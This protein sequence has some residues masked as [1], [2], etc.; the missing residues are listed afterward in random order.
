VA[1]TFTQNFNLQKPEVGASTDTWGTKINANLDIIDDVLS[2][3]RAAFPNVLV[4]TTAN[5]TLSGEQTIDGVLTSASRILVKDQAAP[6]NNGIY[7]TAAGSWVRAGDANSVEEFVLGRSVYVQSGTVGGGR[8]YRVVSSVIS[9]GT[10]PVAFSDAIKQGAA[11]L[12]ATTLAS[13]SVT[14]NETVGGTLSVTGN[15]TLGS[16]AGNSHVVNGNLSVEAGSISTSAGGARGDYLGTSIELAA[17]TTSDVATLIDFHARA[18]SDFDARIVRG[19]GA[20]G[21]LQ[22]DQQGTGITALSHSGVAQFA[23]DYASNFSRVIPGGSTLYPD[24]ACRA[25]VNFNGTGATGNQTIRA[26]GNFTSIAKLSTG[27]YRANFATP[28]P[29]QNYCAEVGQSA[30]GT[31]RADAHIFST[32]AFALSAPSAASFVFALTSNTGTNVDSTYIN[33]SVFR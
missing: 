27:Y 30:D 6:A 21:V 17:G 11:N 32:N 20:N 5:I 29:D 19:G 9:L 22:I 14:G 12:G 26:S 3:A 18:G 23:I 7:V 13:S 15:A 33:I 16:G 28:M 25:W 8:E 10:S 31:I 4:A 1:D 24:F 2:G